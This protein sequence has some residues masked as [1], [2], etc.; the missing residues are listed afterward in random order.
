MRGLSV[1]VF[2]HFP[3]FNYKVIALNTR[4]F[5]RKTRTIFATKLFRDLN[6][7][8]ATMVDGWRSGP[9]RGAAPGNSDPS[10]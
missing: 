2:Q 1:L 3:L 6:A 4:K 7:K 10:P 5:V 8:V 9:G